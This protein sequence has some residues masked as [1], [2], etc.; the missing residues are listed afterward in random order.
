LGVVGLVH[1]PL[2]FVLGRGVPWLL[3]SGGWSASPISF[4]SVGAFFLG[5]RW[6]LSFIFLISIRG[7]YAN[8]NRLYY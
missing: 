3:F 8:Y 4:L 2:G 7:F 6:V 5:V 1:L